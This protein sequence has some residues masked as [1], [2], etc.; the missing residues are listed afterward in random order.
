MSSRWRWAC[1]RAESVDLLHRL[2]PHVAA[3]TLDTIAEELGDLPLALHL[4]GSYLYRYRLALA[5]ADYLAQLRDPALLRHPSLQSQ[6]L[7]PTGHIQHVGRTFALSYDRLDLADPQERLAQ[8]LL[9]CMAHFAPGEPIWYE[10]LV[11]M[12]GVEPADPMQALAVADAFARLVELGLVEHA[13]EHALRMHRLVAAFVRE[14]AAGVLAATQQVV[15]DVVFAEMARINQSGHP[16]PLL[17]RHVHLRAVVDLAARAR[18]CYERRAL[19]RMG[20]APL[21][22]GQLCR[23]APLL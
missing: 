3:A 11:K 14:V 18:R 9:V 23:R 17:A 1:S 20:Q 2:A 13:E 16:V 15:E 10:L 12:S 5:P 7:S 22:G 6:S 8:R 21:S 19:R 4:A